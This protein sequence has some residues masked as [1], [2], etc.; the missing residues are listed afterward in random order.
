MMFLA[1]ESVAAAIIE[2][3]RADGHAVASI[4][5]SASGAVDADVLT[6]AERGGFVLLT[7][8]KDFGEMVYR[9][10]AAHKGVVLIRLGSVASALRPSIVA[11]AVKAHGAELVGAFTVISPGGIR[12]RRP[13]HGRH[14]LFPR[15]CRGRCAGRRAS[16]GRAVLLRRHRAR[17]R[18][19]VRC[20][21]GRGRP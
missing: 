14:P 19:R 13:P 8:D 3:L 20:G 2:Q 10:S 17:F 6:Q 15:G 9:Q 12:I 5:E 21:A 16:E 1:D 18:A 11:Q 4:R 7:E